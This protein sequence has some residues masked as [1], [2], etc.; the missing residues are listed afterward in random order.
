MKIHPLLYIMFV[1]TISVQ[2]FFYAPEIEV[3]GAYCFCPVRH[4]V[5]LS[6][7]NSVFLSE[8]LTLL[9]TFEQ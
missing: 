5:I 4:S 7:C 9:I 3:R 1:Y 2:M 8:T 6:F